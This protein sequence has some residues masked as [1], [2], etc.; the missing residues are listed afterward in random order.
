MTRTHSGP[1]TTGT[2]TAT[3]GASSRR[4]D[5]RL[6][7]GTRRSPIVDDAVVLDL[8]TVD[9]HDDAILPVAIRAALG[10]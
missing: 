3:T 9:P 7:A 6:H 2:R 8:R 1:G 4:K 5:L 10:E